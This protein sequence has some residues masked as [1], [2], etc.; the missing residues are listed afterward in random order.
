MWML[1]EVEALL[2]NKKAYKSIKGQILMLSQYL[3]EM[4]QKGMTFD[5]NFY[6]VVGKQCRTENV[7][8]GHQNNIFI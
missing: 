1:L 6:A 8:A 4:E 3:E 2:F 5:H 7:Y